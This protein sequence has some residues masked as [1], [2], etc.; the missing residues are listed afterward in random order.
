MTAKK[1][2]LIG[3][4]LVCQMILAQ[5]DSIALKEVIVSDYQLKK[6]SDTQSLQ[7]LTDSIIGKNQASLT[8]LLNYNSII[9]FKEN[10]LGM[11]SSPSFRGTTAQQTAVVWNGIN[12]NSQL[13]GQTDFNTIS[14]RDFSDISIRAG[15]GSIIYGSS[16]I[17]GSIHLNNNLSF[18]NRFENEFRLNYGSFNTI[19]ANYKLS[20]SDDKTSVSLSVSRNSSDNDYDY[21]GTKN[22]KN[23]NGQFYNTSVNLAF[24]YK[25]NRSNFLK[26]Y[27]QIFESERHF[28]GTLSG[29]SRSK[30][31]DLNTR[32][33]L[34][35]TAIGNA[36][37]STVKVAFLTEK[38]KFFTNFDSDSFETSKAETF[39][40]KYDL[41]W[42]ITSKINLNGIVDF[43]KTK[44][45]GS[46]IG[47]ET[48]NV[49]SAVLLFKHQL[50]KKLLYEF[51]LRKEITEAYQSP[52]LFAFGSKFQATQNYNLK[53]NVSRN[54]RIPTFNDLYWQ[55][56]GNTDLKPE[57]SYQAEIGQELKFKEFTL[58]ATA[59]CMK[60]EDLLRWKPTMNNWVPENVGKV[61]SYGVETFVNFKKQL[62]SHKLNINST[63]AYTVSKNELLDKQLTY[64]P[65]H[66]FTADAAYSFRKATISYQYLF[67]GQ[68]YILADENDFLKD[69]QVSNLGIDYDFGK[70]NTY[71]IGFQALNILNEKYESVSRRPLPGRNYS[72]NLTLK[73]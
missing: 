43:T 10:G 70:K 7:K 37:R 40:A 19:G 54:F 50:F 33:L 1:L 8:S 42:K 31:D 29:V 6:F 51:S 39:I 13:N 65:Y 15:G 25:L 17:G 35:W 14:T 34:E 58:S 3:F 18:G 32:N 53:F 46:N 49:G 21:I 23:E 52:L 56:A 48:R 45:I 20:A 5:Q 11:V 30:Y 69:Y 4:L 9:Y 2:F 27:S 47:D 44:G 66:K 62:G 28:S 36:I 72:I 57:N 64:V 55:G 63:Y 41:D 22:Q 67:N 68:V 24:G 73:F 16:A 38:Y 60:I 71:K 12:I 26:L 59:Y 61:L